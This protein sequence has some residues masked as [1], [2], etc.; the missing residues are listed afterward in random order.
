MNRH[1]H[2]QKNVKSTRLINTNQL[3]ADFTY[4]FS[5]NSAYAEIFSNIEHIPYAPKR[6]SV[7]R[8][9]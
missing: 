9:Y 2:T 4:L 5:Q 3:N 8:I 7:I 1:Q 6:L